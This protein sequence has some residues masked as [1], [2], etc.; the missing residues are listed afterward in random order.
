MTAELTWSTGSSVAV[1]SSSC[2]SS[3][4]LTSS[5]L[6]R[7]PLLNMLCWTAI[8]TFKD[9]FKNKYIQFWKKNR[10]MEILTRSI[11]EWW[12][13]LPSV[14]ADLDRPGEKHGCLISPF[15][16]T[17]LLYGLWNCSIV[18]CWLHPPP[19]GHLRFT[20]YDR[21]RVTPRMVYYIKI[22]FLCVLCVSLVWWLG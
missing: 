18:S 5:L 15:S 12:S 10:T 16:P 13:W 3:A 1:F 21:I 19:V 20:G 11:A 6:C 22:K 7:A 2:T 17:P 8:Q 4:P 14:F 9:P